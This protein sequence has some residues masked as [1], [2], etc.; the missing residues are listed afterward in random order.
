MIKIRKAICLIDKLHIAGTG[1]T[2][3]NIDKPQRRAVNSF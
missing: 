1:W 2:G 3:K